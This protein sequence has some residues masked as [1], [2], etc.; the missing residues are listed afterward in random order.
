MDLNVAVRFLIL[1]IFLKCF[2]PFS[3]VLRTNTVHMK[4]IM[5]A[6]FTIKNNNDSNKILKNLTKNKSTK[7]Q[8]KNKKK[9]TSPSFHMIFQD[10]SESYVKIVKIVLKVMKEKFTIVDLF[11]FCSSDPGTAMFFS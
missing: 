3:N 11:K 2:I 9:H 7:Y 6:I 5:K 4:T 10:M 1:H 8:T